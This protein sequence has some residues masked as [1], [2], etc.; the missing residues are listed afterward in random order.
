MD[1][2]PKQWLLMSTATMASRISKNS[3]H[4]D[5]AHALLSMQPLI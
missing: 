5:E 4:L 3:G 1:S 2:D